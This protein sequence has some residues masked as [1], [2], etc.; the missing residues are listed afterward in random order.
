VRVAADMCRVLGLS[1]H[2][3]SCGKHFAKLHT[4]EIT[5]VSNTGL[6]LTGSG[7]SS[8]RRVSESGLERRG[9]LG[10][11]KGMAMSSPPRWGAP[12]TR[13]LRHARQESTSGLCGA[14]R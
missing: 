13:R 1:S 5:P 4:D 3:G 8:A 7:M 14:G 11:A 2:K 10:L 9:T 6:K 12:R